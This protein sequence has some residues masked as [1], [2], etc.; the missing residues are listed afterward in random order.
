L[1]N[2]HKSLIEYKKYSKSLQLSAPTPEHYL[3]MLYILALKKENENLSFFNDALVGG[4]FSM[5]SFMIEGF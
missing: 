2:E 1:T 4:S 5:T 3:P